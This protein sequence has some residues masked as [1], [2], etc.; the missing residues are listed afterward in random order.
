MNIDEL[1]TI[2]NLESKKNKTIV[3]IS[4]NY[5]RN[6]KGEF[7]K[8]TKISPLKR[9]CTGQ[10]LIEYDYD[11]VDCEYIIDRIINLE[12]LKDGIYELIPINLGTDFETGYIQDYDYK[13]V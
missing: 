3:R 7:V 11:N 4:R 2:S 13:L 9:K 6:R 12:E 10:Q 5:F 1:M 8:Q